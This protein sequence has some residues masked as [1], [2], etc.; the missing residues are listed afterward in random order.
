M[1]LSRVGISTACYYPQDTYLSFLDVLSA[2][3]PVTE[4]FM[5]SL[6]EIK[7]ENLDRYVAE[8]KAH[9]TEIISFHPYTSA[10]ESL[11][12]FSEYK[13]RVADG[14]EMYKRFFE[15]ASYLGAKY[16]VFHGERNTPTFS[17][18]LADDDCI[19]ESYGRLIETAKQFGLVFTQENVNNHRSHSAEH[20][21]KLR[22]LVPD[23][24]YTFDL[25]QAVRARQDYGDIITAMGDRLCHIHINDYGE[26]EC[27]LPFEG[28]I[29]FIDVKS[30]LDKIN[31]SGDYIVEVYRTNFSGKEDLCRCI[32]KT[33]AVF[34]KTA[35]IYR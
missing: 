16:F 25:K 9:S 30:K 13:E 29:D 35:K 21:K 33:E 15:G 3:V 1:K 34:C 24:K 31:Y 27:C 2:N 19:C 20:I 6:D 18:G 4:I 12:F 26:H 32:A 17:R 8:A 23:L 11:L 10:F 22:R 14:I 28:N 5:N 7:K